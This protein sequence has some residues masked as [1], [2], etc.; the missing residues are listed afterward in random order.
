MIEEVKLN[1]LRAHNGMIPFFFFFGM[2][3]TCKKYCVKLE[4]ITCTL[5][6]TISFLK[7]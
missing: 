2:V 5:V 4:S 1:T 3:S 7:Q 6:Q